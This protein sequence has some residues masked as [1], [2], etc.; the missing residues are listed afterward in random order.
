MKDQDLTIEQIIKDIE[1]Q[2]ILDAIGDPVI[3]NDTDFKIIYQNKASVDFMGNHIGDYCYRAYEQRENVCKDCALSATFNDGKTRTLQRSFPVI[4]KKLHVEITSSPIKD[5]D[6]KIIAGIEVVRDITERKKAEEELQLERDKAQKYLDIAGV[7]IVAIN[8]HQNVTLLNNK[9][10]DILECDK[11]EVI[12]KNWFDNFIP[13]FGRDRV[14]AVF[15][16]LMAGDIES[17]GYFENT[18]ITKS[19]KERIIAWH[20]TM[21]RDSNNN[22]IG[23]LSSGEDITE[24][25]ETEGDLKSSEKKFRILAEK[26]PNMIFINKKGRVV[27]VNERCVEKMGYTKEEF[28]SENFNFMELIAPE[29]IGLVNKNYS[30]HMQGEEISPYEYN[31]VKKSGEKL[32]AIISTSLIDFENDKAILGIIT[33][34]TER[35]KAEEELIKHRE[36]LEE[37]VGE[38]TNDLEISNRYLNEAIKELETFSYSISHDLKAP[39][40]AISGF[41]G[42]LSQDYSGSLD[43][44]G[45]RILNV[46][47]EN[48]VQMG[49]QIDDILKYSRT[50]RK[51]L[52]SGEINIKKLAEGVISELKGDYKDRDIVFDIQEMPNCKGDSVLIKQVLMNLISNAIKFTGNEKK[53]EI[54]LG[55]MQADN[56]IIY[57][58]KDNGVGFNM[59]YA[60]K[61]FGLFQRLHSTKEF[62]GTGVGLALVQ[63]L[64]YKHRGKVWAEAEVNKAATFYFSL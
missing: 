12:G 32:F 18:V 55:S 44:E 36:H 39:L 28:Y 1:K 47:N 62:E 11:N 59:K 27:Y 40:R 29:S 42:M 56:E 63:R 22:I 45:N 2:G 58:V 9:G 53:A 7:I 54:E 61:L 57:Y 49:Q 31:I 6:G 20:N 19:G 4:G 48:A 51:P 5:P 60:D 52:E 8:E 37:L 26:S 10:C 33:D 15:N 64:I 34:I 35:K 13:E 3:I 25:K 23:T 30:R 14:K 41:S 50:A 46:I 17:V 43:E 24:R 38:R 16:K 21:L